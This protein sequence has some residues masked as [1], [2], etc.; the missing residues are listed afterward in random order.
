MDP[1]DLTAQISALAALADPVR[2]SLYEQVSRSSAPLSREQVAREAGVSRAL[3]AFH[4]DKLV[5]AGLLEASFRR[6]SGRTGPGSGRPAKFYSRSTLQVELTLPARRYE[7]AASMFAR[8]LVDVR[9]AESEAALRQSARMQGESIGRDQAEQS[10]AEARKRA[11]RVGRGS[12]QEQEKSDPLSTARSA[13]AHCGFEPVTGPGGEL[14]LR[15]CPFDKL[16]Q[17]CGPMVCDMNLALIEGV[18]TGLGT[19]GVTASLEPEPGHCCVVLRER[20]SG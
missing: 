4:L 10:E 14:V 7:W 6:L 12:D 1:R 2:R 17:G 11:R 8:A 3:A 18:L 9:S 13:L 16:R 5:D 20:A 19:N 15:N